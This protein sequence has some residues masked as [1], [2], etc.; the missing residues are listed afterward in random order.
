MKT[1]VTPIALDKPDHG[2]LL[3]RI[4]LTAFRALRGVTAQAK[5]VPG[6]LAQATQDIKDAWRESARPNA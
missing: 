6:V 1:L 4:S 2:R 3:K 5:E